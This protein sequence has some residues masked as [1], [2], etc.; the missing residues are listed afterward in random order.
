MAADTS[1]EA[2][3]LA[4]R[5]ALVRSNLRRAMVLSAA[6]A[7]LVGLALG[8]QG[9]AGTAS[10]WAAL[11]VA[12]SL[13]GLVWQEPRMRKAL[14]AG[15]LPDAIR[16]LAVF[17]VVFGL[18]WGAAGLLF[19]SPDPARLATLLVMLLGILIAV[20][21]ASS[22]YL[23]S[24]WC[25]GLPLLLPFILRAAGSGDTLSQLSAGALL[26]IGGTVISH[27]SRHHSVLVGAIRMRFENARLNEELVELRVRERTRALELASEHKSAFL[28]TVSH[29]IR[30]PLNAIIGMSG[31]LV[32]TPLSDEQREF[33]HIVRD[34][35][36]S[37]LA[38]INDILDY[39]KIEAGRMD[40]ES[41]PFDLRECVESALD[42]V[43]S[44]AADRGLEL[45]CRIDRDV[46]A[47]VT[48]D[49]TRLRQVL[50]NLLANAVKFTEHGEVVLSVARE[51]GDVL[52]F[53]VR[54]TGIGL[55][56]EG[57]ARLFQSFAQADASTSRK[58]GG[59]GLGLAI[60]RRLAEAMGGAMTARS[61]G[62][63]RGSI[64]AFT[65]R[66]PA[67]APGAADAAVARVPADGDEAFRGKRVMIIEAHATHRDGLA[68]Q[69]GD[70]GI[71]CDAYADPDA[72]VAGWAGGVRSN[73][74]VLG[75]RRRDAQAM[76]AARRLRGVVGDLP[77]VL[78][79][80]VG[81]REPDEE[82]LYAAVLSRP[83]HQSQL[84]DALMTLFAGAAPSRL[85][86]RRQRVDPGLAERHPL[87]ILLAEDNAVNQKLALRLLQQ[88]GYRADV[89]A[90]G[91]E[92]VESVRRQ[93]YDVVLMDVQMPEMDG[94]EAT[95]EIVGRFGDDRPRIVAM[96]A[97][98]MQG[99]REA[100]LASGMDDYLTKPIRVEQLMQALQSSPARQDPA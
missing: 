94:L 9:L 47:M 11:A 22:A 100:C 86:E 21:M 62:P 52:R 96:T 51:A 75:C 95:R 49:P 90:S 32:D 18:V 27:A 99:D 74:V 91:V 82:A 24:V 35:G 48:G 37:L 50:L 39:S 58:Y 81:R 59:T 68:R 8:S 60:S 87:R 40:I 78:L 5:L 56:A 31:L 23:S 14:E 44:K 55:T 97:N 20:A 76:E 80:P 63:G 17:D 89:A 10:I 84:F 4:E 66:A 69:L 38:L 2:L 16:L 26:L 54:D 28:A 30:T 61:D 64:F 88:M 41:H 71:G 36:E 19:Y 46:P 43:A 57:L 79:A 34:S 70:W 85:A 29:E 65:I 45:A 98:A 92:A 33:A 73:A 12:W 93:R 42:L 3:I 53:E 13:S 1:Q 77:L 83:L 6:G 25:V 72:A 7:V 67:V 15:R